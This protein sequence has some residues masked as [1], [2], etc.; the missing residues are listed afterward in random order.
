MEPITR[1]E[2]YLA[3][4][5][6]NTAGGGGGTS[7]LTVAQVTVTNE[8]TSYAQI[9]APV[10]YED[11]G[12]ATA[13]TE[14]NCTPA[15]R[16]GA[17]QTFRCILYKGNA[18]IYAILESIGADCQLTVVSGEA[19]AWGDNQAGITGDAVLTINAY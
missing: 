1:I 2:K 17:T 18:D 13:Q 11:E 15:G 10:I 4:I 19:E 8:T 6:E 16:D 12:W 5:V 7:D 9:I 14:I 3:E